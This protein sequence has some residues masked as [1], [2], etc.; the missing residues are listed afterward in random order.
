M[1]FMKNR[2]NVGD[3]AKKTSSP[4]CTAGIAG[5]NR[6]VAGNVAGRLF[7]ETKKPGFPEEAGFRRTG[8]KRC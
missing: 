3:A 6:K 8:R 5:R 2:A 7:A 4:A 1:G